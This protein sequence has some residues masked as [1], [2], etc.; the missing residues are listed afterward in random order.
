MKIACLDLE[1]VLSPEVWLR[2]A[3]DT[4]IDDLRMTTRDEPDYH[5]LMR[6]RIEILARHGVRIQDIRRVVAGLALLPGAA[7]FWLSLRKTMGAVIVSDTF[8]EFAEPIRALLGYPVLLCN[9]L[10]IDDEG[11]IVDFH[12]R[13]EQGK[14]EA[15]SSLRTL[16]AKVFAVGDSFNDLEMIRAADAGIL[17]RASQTVLDAADDLPHTDDY[18]EL[19]RFFTS[20]RA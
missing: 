10:E 20:G 11:R 3:D 12:M 2:L 16:N 18:G 5:K 15:V 1:G 7:E 9:R 19:L 6:A 4:G 13:K 14:R 8:A 17:F